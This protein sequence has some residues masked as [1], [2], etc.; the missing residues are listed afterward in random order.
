MQKL[1]DKQDHGRDASSMEITSVLLLY[2]SFSA[3]SPSGV[4]F[5]FCSRPFSLIQRSL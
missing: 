2:I 1:E 3:T 4:Q 5:V